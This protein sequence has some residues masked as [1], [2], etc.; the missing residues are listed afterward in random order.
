MR[1]LGLGLRVVRA[2]S[3]RLRVMR[4][5]GLR[6]R[7]VR[8]GLGVRVRVVSTWGMRR[9]IGLGVRR[10]GGGV[11]WCAGGAKAPP[12]AACPAPCGAVYCGGTDVPC[13]GVGAGRWT[14]GAGAQGPGPPYG[15]VL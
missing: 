12:S 10:R 3:L 15:G 5:V 8:I 9:R 4:D 2:V 14:G 13:A 11:C 6:L 7:V 1:T